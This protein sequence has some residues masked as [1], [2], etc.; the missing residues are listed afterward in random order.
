MPSRNHP[1][2]ALRV[3]AVGN[4]HV[5]PLGLQRKV[6][7]SA[8]TQGFGTAS[9]RHSGPWQIDVARPLNINT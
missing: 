6:Y 3:I 9:R 7:S 8:F 4:E 2:I 5:R 1:L